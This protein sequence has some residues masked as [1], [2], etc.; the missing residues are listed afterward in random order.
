MYN[1]S[2]PSCVN[3]CPTSLF[4]NNQTET[5]TGCDSS[6]ATCGLYSTQCLSCPAGSYL[7]NSSCLGSCSL[8]YYAIGTIC[9][10]CPVECAVCTSSQSCSQCA[11]SYYLYLSSCVDTCPSIKPVVNVNG[12]CSSCADIYCISCNS[13]NYCSGCYF[14]KVLIQGA[15]VA[16]CP[17]DY[18][19]DENGTKCIYSPNSNTNNNTT[20]PT[21]TLTES[22]T[23]SSTFPVPF[24]VAA[25]FIGVACLM[26]KF[27]HDKT[28]VWSALYALWGLL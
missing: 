10:A 12:V 24:T 17:I 3:P 18:V 19:L 21:S 1:V 14:P 20:S 16:N 15:C 11:F 4:M 2:T 27:Q 8:G 28:F 13:S 6:C 22:L 25:G 7:Q 5:C 23:T 9:T 26:S